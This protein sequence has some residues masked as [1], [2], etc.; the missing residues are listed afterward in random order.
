LTA[1]VGESLVAEVSTIFGRSGAWRRFEVSTATRIG[2]G[3]GSLRDT[4]A[5]RDGGFIL[6]VPAHP[7]KAKRNAIKME[8]DEK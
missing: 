4:G 8:V 5:G 3:L 1:L 6:E 2:A 7:T